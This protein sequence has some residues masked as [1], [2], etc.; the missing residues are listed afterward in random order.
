MRVAW[1]R[2]HIYTYT[3]VFGFEKKLLNNHWLSDYNC[4]KMILFTQYND[5]REYFEVV[6]TFPTK[7]L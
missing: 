7:I 1:N 3:Y 2:A 4:P 6:H 5:K